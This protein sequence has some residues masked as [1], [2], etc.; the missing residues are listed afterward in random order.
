MKKLNKNILSAVLSASLTVTSVPFGSFGTVAVD[1]ETEINAP[2]SSAVEEPA[3]AESLPLPYEAAPKMADAEAS[4]EKPAFEYKKDNDGNAAISVYNGSATEVVIP[5]E[6][7]GVP[8]V[9]VGDDVFKDKAIASV[10][11][12][13]GVKTIGSRAFRNCDQLKEVIL[14]ETVTAIGNEAFYNCNSLVTVTMPKSL[15]TIG[16][17]AFAENPSLIAVELPAGTE[18]V[19]AYA[20]H[21]CDALTRTSAFPRT[22]LSAGR[23]S[24]TVKSSTRL[25][26]RAKLLL[27]V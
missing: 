7:D 25:C 14:P 8:V 20:F 17:Y 11:I 2:D 4:A 10:T 23:R 24:R 1:N 3:S 15:K 19:G 16:T 12:P 9:A 26:S 18:S 5:A 13:K 21:N 27:S 6:I 22:L